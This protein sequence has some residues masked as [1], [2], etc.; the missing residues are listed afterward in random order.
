MLIAYIV[1]VLKAIMEH[2]NKEGKRPGELPFQ[3]FSHRNEMDQDSNSCSYVL[4][5]L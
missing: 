1:A 3:I 5:T 2:I 4:E